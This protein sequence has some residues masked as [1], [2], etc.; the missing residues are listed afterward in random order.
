[1]NSIS[2]A[3][4]GAIASNVVREQWRAKVSYFLAAYG[5]VLVLALALLPEIAAGNTAGKILL[6]LSL[7]GASLMGLAVAVF[8]GTRILDREIERRTILLSIAKPLSRTEFILGKHLGL[9]IVLMGVALAATV[10]GILVLLPI[11]QVVTD[12]G[13]IGMTTLFAMVELVLIAAIALLFSAITNGILASGLTLAVYLMGHLSQDLLTIGVQLD[14]PWLQR[15][16]EILYI[17]LPDL[18]RLNLKNLAVYGILPDG[19]TLAFDA[20]YGICYTAIVLCLTT[21]IFARREF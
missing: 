11:G 4:I 8:T 19:G 14:S 7:A 13:A 10:M 6:D 3:R 9:S 5:L 20:L 18:E 2:V 15:L 16:T 1:M 21:F 17:V 12:W